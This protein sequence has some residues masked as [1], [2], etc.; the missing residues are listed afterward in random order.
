[1]NNITVSDNYVNAA[2]DGGGIYLEKGSAAINYATI[3]GDT[4]TYA[5]GGINAQ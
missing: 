4:G 1:M 2:G 5:G 3:S